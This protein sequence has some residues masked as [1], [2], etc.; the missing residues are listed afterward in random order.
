[1]KETAQFFHINE[2]VKLSEGATRKEIVDNE[3]G[4]RGSSRNTASQDRYSRQ[5][6]K[7]ERGKKNKGG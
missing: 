5:K 4:G 6:K 3:L 2:D 1:M 7:L